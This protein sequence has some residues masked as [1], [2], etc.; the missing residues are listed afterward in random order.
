MFV[1]RRQELEKLNR[2]YDSGKF[3]LVVISGRRH[4]GKT[5]LISEFTKEKRTICFSAR[6]LTDKYN[7]MAFEAA[8]RKH[9]ADPEITLESWADGFRC[10]GQRIGDERCLLVFENY[11]DACLTNKELS[12]LIADGI[13]EYLKSGKVMLIL[14]GNHMAALEREVL[15]KKSI[16]NPYVT[17]RIELACLPFEEAKRFMQSFNEDDQYKLY[18]SV[19][20]TPL[21]LS[22]IDN[23]ISADENILKLFLD[24]CGFL[25]N[26]IGMTLQKELIGPVVYNSLLR[27]VAYGKTKAREILDETGE[28]SGKAHKYLNVLLSMGILHRDIPEGAD[29]NTSRKGTWRFT[30]NAHRFWYRYVLDNQERIDRGEGRTVLNEVSF[31]DTAG[32]R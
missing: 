23:S 10:I 1:G 28:E 19:G 17:E 12:G 26:D 15:G 31:S 21:Y 9:F 13:R 16:L 8:L 24:R 3:E 5:S 30:D 20:G 32:K 4:I 6:E 27:A 18:G 7:L 2:A 14:S 29:P 22:L 25:Y 11:T